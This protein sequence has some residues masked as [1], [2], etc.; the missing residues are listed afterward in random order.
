MKG[1]E[2]FCKY[3]CNSG[4]SENKYPCNGQVCEEERKTVAQ[5]SLITPAV[6]QLP[7]WCYI[8]VPWSRT[9]RGK[10]NYLRDSILTPTA[11]HL[12][13]WTWTFKVNI[14]IICSA[15]SWKRTV[16]AFA[17]RMNT[18]HWRGMKKYWTFHCYY[19]SSDFAASLKMKMHAMAKNM[20]YSREHCYYTNCSAVAALRVKI[21]AM[22]KVKRGKKN[23]WRDH[24]YYTS[25][26]LAG[27]LMMK[28][29]AMA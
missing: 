26:S 15:A 13:A 10:G 21:H 24:C 4:Y 6:A 1:K 7:G 18:L 5:I 23:Y 19:A 20:S 8:L 11:D 9:W 16:Q 27:S 29:H 25:S 12:T 3:Y 2:N 14:H 22:V 17:K 28:M